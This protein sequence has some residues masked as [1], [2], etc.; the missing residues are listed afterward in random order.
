[1]FGEFD[2][3]EKLEIGSRVTRLTAAGYTM[4]KNN[5]FNDV[6]MPAIAIRRTNRTHALVKEIE[7]PSYVATLSVSRANLLCPD[8]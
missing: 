8:H 7:L 2:F 3:P 1:M 5:W 6:A 4:V